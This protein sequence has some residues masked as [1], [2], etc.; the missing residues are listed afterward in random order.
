MKIKL[1]LLIFCIVTVLL[2]STTISAE[3][4]YKILTV[5]RCDSLIK[6]NATNPNFVILD[7]RTHTEWVNDHLQGS[8]NRS[9]RDSE[10]DDQLNALPKHKIFLIHCQSGGRSA[11]AFTTM[12][13]LEFAEVYEM[14]GG[15]GSWKGNGFP[16]TSVLAPKLMLV[17]YTDSLENSTN[18]DT[19]N[20]TITNRANEILTFTSIT[21][22]DFHVITNNFDINKT[23]GG[24]DDY[25]FSIFHSPGYSEDDSTNIFIESNGGELELN[26]VFKDGVIQTIDSDF[27]KNKLVVYPNPAKNNLYVKNSS[28]LNI[29]EVSVIN[30]KGQIIFQNNYYSMYNGI[31]ISGL[32]SGI[33]FVRIKTENELFSEKVII[34]Q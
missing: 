22:N 2:T 32:K 13:N 24:A 34:R 8:I 25:T 28:L 33:Y 1:R 23:I 10:F 6:A 11:G 27:L 14:Q 20:I 5:D 12:Q 16:T 4:I 17:S 26:I 9:T 21:F 29:E 31:D 7:V 30:L 3:N 15:I 19:I 18:S